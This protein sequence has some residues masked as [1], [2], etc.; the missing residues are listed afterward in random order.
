MK[1]ASVETPFLRIKSAQWLLKLFKKDRAFLFTQTAALNFGSPSDDTN[2]L[3]HR[4][5]SATKAWE[6][7]A[8]TY[9]GATVATKPRE[10]EKPGSSSRLRG[11]EY[12]V[13]GTNHIGKGQGNNQHQVHWVRWSTTS[14][15]HRFRNDIPTRGKYFS[16]E[17]LGVPVRHAG[18]GKQEV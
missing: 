17:V 3:D 6:Q 4:T 11:S 2:C 10:N 5:H 12:A 16:G 18:R 13:H 15:T 1:A 7:A 8:V 9:L 14:H